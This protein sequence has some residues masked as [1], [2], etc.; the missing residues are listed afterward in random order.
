MAKEGTLQRARLPRDLLAGRGGLV[1]AGD[2]LL[3]PAAGPGLLLLR[4]KVG[5]DNCLDGLSSRLD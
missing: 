4:K 2:Y 5:Q 1:P 3:L